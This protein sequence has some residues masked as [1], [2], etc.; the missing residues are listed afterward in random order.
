MMSTDQKTRTKSEK[1][2]NGSSDETDIVMALMQ[3]PN[4]NSFYFL[5]SFRP[6]SKKERLTFALYFIK[7]SYPR[8]LTVEWQQLRFFCIEDIAIEGFDVSGEFFP[9]TRQLLQLSHPLGTSHSFL[10]FDKAST[11]ARFEKE[12]ALRGCVS[13]WSLKEDI[14]NISTQGAWTIV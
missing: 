8:L 2:E 14:S 12:R 6:Q 11:G 1:G 3:C 9:S 5:M 4:A 10:L 7:L 13:F